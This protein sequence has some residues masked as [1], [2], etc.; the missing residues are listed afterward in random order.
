MKK[1]ILSLAAVI[2]TWTLILIACAGPLPPINTD[3]DGLALKGYDPVAY[4]TL[5]QPVKGRQEYRFEWKNAT[6]LFSSNKHLILF[7]EDPARY[8]PQYGGY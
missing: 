6:W 3:A 8:A 7:Q 2:S 4:F 5:G 1:P